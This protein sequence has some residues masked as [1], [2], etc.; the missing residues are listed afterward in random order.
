MNDC[1]NETQNDTNASN[2]NV[3]N[4]QKVVMAAGPRCC[5]DYK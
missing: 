3:C 5:T 2:D 1:K 4:A